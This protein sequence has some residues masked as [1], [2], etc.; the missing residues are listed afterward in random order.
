MTANIAEVRRQAYRAVNQ[1]GLF[2]LGLGLGLLLIAGWFALERFAE[3]QMTGVFAILPMV[4]LFLVRGMRKRYT[5]PRVG[6]ANLKTGPVRLG[7]MIGLLVTI[8]LVLAT[9]L[10]FQFTSLRVPRSILGYLPTFLGLL[11]VG[12]LAYF[13][14]RTGYPRYLVYAGLVLALLAIVFLLRAEAIFTF[15]VPAAVVGAVMLVTGI[16]TFI[17]FLRAHPRVEQE[18]SDAT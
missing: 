9:F 13:T 16:A 1:D 17:R 10:A 6:Y 18:A 14:Y 8:L 12:G 15:I 3:V 4:I 5:Y 7:L 11:G 2:D